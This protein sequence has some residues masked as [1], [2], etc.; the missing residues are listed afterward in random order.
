MDHS[1]DYSMGIF[2]YQKDS[3]RV[4]SLVDAVD[5]VEDVVLDIQKLVEPAQDLV[6]V[7]L[8]RRLHE[9]LQEV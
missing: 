8:S 4:L 5:M 6:H 9:V 3:H 1:G 2:P 7:G